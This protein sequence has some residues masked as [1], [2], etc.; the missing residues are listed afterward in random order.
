MDRLDA[1]ATQGTLVIQRL[2][3]RARLVFDAL[4]KIRQLGLVGRIGSQAIGTIFQ[5]AHDV[6]GQT[7]S[8]FFGNGGDHIDRTFPLQAVNDFLDPLFVLFFEDLV[9]LVQHQAHGW[10]WT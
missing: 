2:Q 10:Y 9:A 5:V 6:A 7:L 1:T 8:A 3:L 4:I